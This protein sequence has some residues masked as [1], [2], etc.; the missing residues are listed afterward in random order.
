MG[1]FSAVIDRSPIDRFG[2]NAAAQSL[3]QQTQV[4]TTRADQLWDPNSI[5][6]QLQQ[7]QL[8]QN[9][10]DLQAGQS[11]QASRL[12]AKTGGAGLATAAALNTG[13]G[14][15]GQQ[16]SQASI[17]AQSQATQLAGQFSSQAGQF[18]SQAGSLKNQLNQ[19][20]RQQK[21][22]NQQARQQS[23]M[24]RADA[25][26]GVIGTVA[27]PALGAI[28]SKISDAITPPTADTVFD[29]DETLEDQDPFDPGNVIYKGF[30]S[31]SDYVLNENVGDLDFD[32]TNTINTTLPTIDDP[33]NEPLNEPVVNEPDF[34]EL[35]NITIANLN[36]L[37]KQE[38][39][40][41]YGITVEELENLQPKSEGPGLTSVD[42]DSLFP[43]P[44]MDS[45]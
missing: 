27:G 39:A 41:K 24:A 25:I 17:A 12:A 6:N 45:D 40:N 42:E 34:S 20:Y 23:R 22:A 29:I 16:V 43:T 13:V 18:S 14:K 3:L 21:Q 33:L 10:H 31:F 38:L 37:Q 1:L 8:M 35:N 30:K 11:L 15:L 7:Q 9:M 19:L 26:M 36:L 2:G 28:G 4:A 32:T 44:D 5:R